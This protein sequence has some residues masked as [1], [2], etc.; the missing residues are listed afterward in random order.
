M[1]YVVTLLLLIT[2][3]WPLT[4]LA[5]LPEDVAADFSVISGYVVMPV[6]DEYI[7]DRHNHVTADHREIGGDIFRQLGQYGQ[8][9]QEDN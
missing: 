3:L 2:L 8:W 6:N 4:A 9:I 5:E 1:K 7:V